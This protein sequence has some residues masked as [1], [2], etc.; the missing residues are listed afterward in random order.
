MKSRKKNKKP[1]LILIL[2][3]AIVFGA[4]YFFKEHFTKVEKEEN[5]PEILEKEEVEKIYNVSFTL[6]GNVLVN[7]DMWSDT[8]TMDGHDFN[9]IFKLLEETF[10]KSNINFYTQQSIVGGNDLGESAVYD[11][12]TPTE[13]FI[14]TSKLDF[15]LISFG[16]YHAYDRG[17]EGI[18]NTI[19]YLTENK[20]N[21]SG[22][23]DKEDRIENN[24]IY[25]NGIKVGLLSYTLNTDEKVSEEYAVKK[26]SDEVAKKDIEELK[27]KV[28]VI[29]VSID[30]NN[31][32]S[33]AVTEEQKRVAEYLSNLGVNIIVGNTSYTIQPIEMVN[34]TLVCYSLGNLLS[35]HYSVDS[36]ISSIIDFNLKITKLGEKTTIEFEDINVLLTYA[37]NR[38]GIQ[39]KIIPFTKITNELLNYRT[40]Y[41]KYKKL[42]TENNDKVKL[43][44]IGE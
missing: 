41:E 23:K 18:E 11:Y 30:W 35:G 40:Y 24:I 2:L 14:E 38:G 39:Y 29:M 33:T 37:Y 1:L 5:T 31:L 27:Q 25:K 7:S 9:P 36:R 17:I 22:I 10:K 20:I 21:Y 16:S 13:I 44:E 4:L 42:L 34:N 3:I 6:A 28:D 26:Y 43:Y 19:K 12:N 32:N 15:N 8:K